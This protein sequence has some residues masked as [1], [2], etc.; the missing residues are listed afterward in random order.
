MT[1]TYKLTH[2]PRNASFN[3]VVYQEQHPNIHFENIELVWIPKEKVWISP[4][5][6]KFSDKALALEHCK[7]LNAYYKANLEL[8]IRRLT[9]VSNS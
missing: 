4:T 3:R 7:V 5:G 9:N 6:K 2:K 1:L 8:K